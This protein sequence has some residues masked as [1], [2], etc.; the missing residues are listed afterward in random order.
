MERVRQ[1]N[2]VYDQRYNA[3]R[4][5][6]SISFKLDNEMD[7]ELLKVADAMPNFGEWVK[8]KLREHI[9]K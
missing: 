2:R 8:E 4:K 7:C 5:N 9:K 3:K 1:P 6:K